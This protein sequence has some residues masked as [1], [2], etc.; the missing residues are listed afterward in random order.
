MS[1]AVIGQKETLQRHS[2]LLF[3]LL[4]LHRIWHPH[5]HHQNLLRL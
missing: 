3:R 4:H 5:I 1:S 2:T